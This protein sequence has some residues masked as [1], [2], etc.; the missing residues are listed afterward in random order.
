MH[1]DQ[2]IWDAK[3]YELFG[4]EKRKGPIPLSMFINAV[5]PNDRVRIGAFT[6]TALE[7][8][9]TA[10]VEYRIIHPDG[11][12][13]WLLGHCGMV[14]PSENG[15]ES[16]SLCIGVNL[17]ITKS[18]HI[19]MAL[20]ES[21]RQLQAVN[22]T[23]EHRITERTAQ[24]E[25]EAELHKKTQSELAI[26]RRLDSIGQLAGGV[27]HDFN[28]LL[29]AIGSNL[30]LAAPY[31]THDD[32]SEM[33]AAARAAVETGT[34]LN[35]R[36][37]TFARKQ[38]L[39]PVLLSLN[40]QISETVLLLERTLGENYL[41][42]MELQPGLWNVFIDAGEIASA[43]VN[44]S[45][46]A[47]DAMPR[48]GDIAIKTCNMVLGA[49]DIQLSA[50]DKPGEYVG[51]FVTDTGPG[52]VPEVV[53]KA[54]EPFFTTKELGKGEG[55]GL[56]SVYGFVKESGGLLQLD[57]YPDNGTTVR[58]LLPRSLKALPLKQ[59]K[60]SEKRTSRSNNELILVVEDNP[61][62]R[63]ATVRC[64]NILGYRVL[65]ASNAKDAI[66]ELKKGTPVNLVFT[67]IVLPGGMTGYELADWLSNNRKDVM[68][69][70][71]SGYIDPATHTNSESTTPNV[72][73]LN[74]P[75]P[76]DLLAQK[77]SEVLESV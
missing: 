22:Q 20:R 29:A 54:L 72:E 68:L 5:H 57:S 71:T 1:S 25:S 36:L 67:D 62:V 53:E 27:A 60:N 76:M 45:L 37:L 11:S 52:M 46:N 34:S 24:L 51:V 38:K 39:S 40:D 55:L 77:V 8:G 7:E 30:E 17:D 63:K 9:I 16:S 42:T 28:N 49:D 35:Q 19:E 56:S 69:L 58:I 32:A 44:L 15:T 73:I 2:I 33:I 23:L 59:A 3:Q 70:L 75:Y 26:T 65:E 48:G 50:G 61:M 6:Q 64:L 43:L 47:R 18:K 10:I 41:I 13:R 21:Q 74:K 66:D 4:L 14:P 12:I 31:V